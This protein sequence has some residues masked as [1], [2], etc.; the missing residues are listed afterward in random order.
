[1]SLK[2]VDS[3][4]PFKPVYSIYEHEFLGCIIS[5]HVV[6][7]LENGRLSLLHQG[8]YPD[9]LRQFQHGLDPIDIQLVG[10]LDQINPKKIL[11]KFGARAKN[12][13]DFYENIF[14]GEIKELVLRFI[15]RNLSQAL[16]LMFDRIVGTMGNDGYPAYREVTM[17]EEQ[18]TVLFHFHKE[19]EGTRYYPTIKLR[20]E[21]AEFMYKGATLV[22]MEPAWMLLN[23]ELFTFRKEL[24]GKKLKP[25]LN[26]R[27]IIIPHKSEEVYYQKF[28]T[29]LIENYDVYARGFD[30]QPVK[31]RPDFSLEVKGSEKSMGMN[32]NVEYDRF[33]FPITDP[34]EVKV[35]MEKEGEE[36]TFYRIMRDHSKEEEMRRYM[37]SLQRFGGES[38]G[39]RASLLEWEYMEKQEALSW[40][41]VNVDRLREKNIRVIQNMGEE[42]LNFQKPELLME[43]SED[44]DWFDIRAVV[45]IAGYSIPFIKFRH[46]ILTNKR[47]YVLPD[48]S[49]A[50]LPDSWFTEYRHLVEVAEEKKEGTLSIRKYQAGLM[51]ARG[52]LNE[53]LRTKIR[54]LTGCELSDVPPPQ[55]LQAT[56]RDYQTKG[57]YWLNFLNHYKFGGILADD[58]GLGKTLQT[59]SLLQKEK[60][61]NLFMGPSLI[62]MPTSLIYNWQ[63]E[64]RKFTPNLSVMV[65][66]GINRQ[67][68]PSVFAGYD[69]ILTT[70]GIVRQDIE[71]MEKFPFHYVILDE[72]QMIKNPASKTNKAVRKL[73]SKHRLSLT[74]TPIENTLMDLWSQ[75]AFLNPGLLGGE[76]FFKEFYVL[77]IEKSQDQER[78][79]QLRRLINPFILRRTKEQVASELPPK[80]E[81][82]HFCEMED[83]QKEVYEEVR[84]S[85]RNFL[86]DLIN[87]QSFNKNKF[88][89]MAGLQKLR[90]IAI[91]PRLVPEGGPN[92]PSAKYEEFKRMLD[93]VLS[94]GSKVLVFSQFVKFLSLIR[95][96]LDKEGITYA[97]LDGSTQDRQA[98][99]KSFQEDPNVPVFLISLKAGGVGINLTAAEYV[100]ILDPWWNPAVENQAIDRSHRIGQDKTVF[101][102]KFI[103]RDSIEEKIIRLQEVKAKLSDEIV[104]EQELFKSFSQEDILNLLN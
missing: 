96:D 27:C 58:M 31:A 102:Y 80:I 2:L 103:T 21:K 25:F 1:M 7:E 82:I 51:E 71:F 85:Y 49:T 63:E 91:D 73:V 53:D 5:A 48:G 42:K 90:Q 84:N 83:E 10:I 70:Y 3:S 64:A 75:M 86:L 87:S 14:V 30:I 89:I 24:D 101:I 11:K 69:L 13:H 6:Q 52:V 50:I 67:R 95:K 26:K 57:Y 74:G 44:G 77:P 15:S 40:L 32:L 28:I 29:S 36:Y 68:D 38:I 56:L 19:A 20:G 72:S 59:L 66:S 8:L 12:I 47:D 97:Y 79:D 81:T 104:G 4:K 76:K 16:P 34:G 43:T 41:Q 98:E 62:V 18:A 35:V 54:R 61:N 39:Q 94:K 88:N 17:L 23:D 37:D 22:C 93:D 60:E 46:H 92:I 33:N 99:V 55:F 45:R 65:H 100:F 9:N 78:R